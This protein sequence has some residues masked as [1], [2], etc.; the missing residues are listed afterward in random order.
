VRAND[1]ITGSKEFK[2]KNATGDLPCLETAEGCITENLAIIKYFA[3]VAPEKKLLGSS[4]IE[5]A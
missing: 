3:R 4:A 5:R 2:Q 1:D